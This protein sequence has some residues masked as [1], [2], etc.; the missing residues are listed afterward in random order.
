M[1]RYHYYYRLSNAGIPY[2]AIYTPGVGMAPK[3][4]GKA[5]ADAAAT[6]QPDDDYEW[7]YARTYE[8][9]SAWQRF[10]RVLYNHA[11]GTVLG[12][13]GKRWGQ[14]FI[15]YSL[16]YCGLAILFS[17]CMKGMMSTISDSYPR[18]TLKDS[19]IGTNPGMG[20]RPM[21]ENVDEGSMITFSSTN[22]SSTDQWVDSIENFL[23]VYTEE[24]RGNRQIC[25]YDK[26]PTE[27]KVCNVDLTNPEWKQ[28]S[29]KTSY[30]YKSASP[31]VFLK[32]NRIYGWVPEYYNDPND[33]PADMP[34]DLVSYIKAHAKQ[35]EK[36]NTVWVSCHGEKEVDQEELGPIEYYPQPGF[37][38]YFYPYTNKEGYLSP[39]VAVHFKRPSVNQ[40][41]NIECRVWAKNVIYSSS[42]LEREGSVR[43]E[44]LID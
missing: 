27:G 36:L 19:L 8:D 30:G 10:H 12:R 31:C 37:P 22:A 7:E 6:S 9:L 35:K 4:S 26:P 29:N 14:L 33:L 13:T 24:P 34:P 32:L 43:F 41:L 5:K 40:L 44:I 28:C 16:F 17:I 38:G 23:K 11:D 42:A 15:F 3:G 1:Y 20:F 25:D 21:P 18:W 39:L 2:R